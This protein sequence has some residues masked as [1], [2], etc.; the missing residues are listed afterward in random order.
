[1]ERWAGKTAIVTGAASGI[2]EAI[3]AELIRHGVNVIATDVNY[4]GL[5]S[6]ASNWETL[7]NSGEYHLM[8]CDVSNEKD[9][10]NVFS[11]AETLGGVNIMVNNAGFVD[12]SYVI[13]TNWQ[14]MEKMLKVFML[15]TAAFMI[16]ASRSMSK[17]NAEGHIININS[18]LGLEHP[19]YTP[20]EIEQ[21]NGCNI[22]T[23]C[24]HGTVA[25][26]EVVRRELA[27]T[28]SKIRVTSICPGMVDTNIGNHDK[29]VKENRKGM[30]SLK[31]L[32]IASAAI[33]AISTRPEV[34]VSEVIVRPQGHII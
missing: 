29:V 12:F 24:K 7:A 16:R 4:K 8:Q 18:V 3:T 13:D 6:A 2:G 21:R 31:P 5:K 28:G 20:R 26:T 19:V 1:M 11:F 15:G 30:T 23:A 27:Q 14:T 33:Y 10:D 25:L 22:Y 9:I 34:E 17:Q 32:D